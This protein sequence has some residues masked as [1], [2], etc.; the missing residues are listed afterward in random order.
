MNFRVFL[1]NSEHLMDDCRLANQ[2]GSDEFKRNLYSEMIGHTTNAVP[3]V[4]TRANDNRSTTALTNQ[5]AKLKH[6]SCYFIF[7]ILT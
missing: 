6:Y 1:M 2:Y 7:R 5:D 3:R 4:R